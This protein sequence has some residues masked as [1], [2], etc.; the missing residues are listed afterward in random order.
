MIHGHPLLS[1]GVPFAHGYRVVGQRV[2]VDRHAVRGTDLVLAAVTA[3]DGARVVSLS[4]RG[5]HHAPIRWD[6]VQFTRGYEKWAAYGQSKTANVLFAVHLDKLGAEKGVQVPGTRQFRN[7]QFMT[8]ETRSTTHF[9]WN[10]L[11]DFDLDNPN[12]A[13]SLR[14]SLEEA[15]GEDLA[16]TGRL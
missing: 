14:H 16:I 9:F 11:H 8:P 2:D 3:A 10:Y 4:S 15:F 12:I 7:A 1:H 6:D 5:H 13:L